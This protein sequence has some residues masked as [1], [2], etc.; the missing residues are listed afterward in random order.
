MPAYSK[1]GSKSATAWMA[2]S[3]DNRRKSHRKDL[4]K[5]FEGGANID[6]WLQNARDALR[7]AKNK[8]HCTY[9]VEHIELMEEIKLKKA[10]KANTEAGIELETRTWSRLAEAKEKLQ[11]AEI[12]KKEALEDI[13]DCRNI[14]ASLSISHSTT[15]SLPACTVE[16]VPVSDTEDSDDDQPDESK[17]D[18]NL[19]SN[20]HSFFQTMIA[21]KEPSYYPV[22]QKKECLRLTDGDGDVVMQ[23][24]RRGCAASTST[25]NY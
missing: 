13:E 8:V 24:R 21:K 3:A 20:G 25:S 4:E 12:Q 15:P 18:D 5:S 7:F 16:E 17:Y 11:K 22:Q 2:I 9:L 14:L 1:L 19:I 23:E 6:L 10:D